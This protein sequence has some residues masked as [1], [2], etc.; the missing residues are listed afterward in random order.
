[1]KDCFH[2]KTDGILVLI[3]IKFVMEVLIVTMD[4]MKITV[5]SKLECIKIVKAVNNCCY[6]EIL[7]KFIT[8]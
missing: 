4:M 3:Q 5:V 8:E 1:M 7:M 2:V 6:T